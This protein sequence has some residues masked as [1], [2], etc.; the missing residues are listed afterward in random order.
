MTG[1]RGGRRREELVEEGR[2]DGDLGLG[3]T[4]ERDETT[5]FWEFF[6]GLG[7][8]DMSKRFEVDDN[9]GGFELNG[10]GL[11]CGPEGMEFKRGPGPGL[12]IECGKSGSWAVGDG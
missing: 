8:E 9:S 7:L 11:K 10:N 3:S 1:D 12:R 2:G 6:G 5:G 4:F